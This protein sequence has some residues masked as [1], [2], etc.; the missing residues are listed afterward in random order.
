L[1]VGLGRYGVAVRPHF[2]GDRNAQLIV[3][4]RITSDSGRVLVSAEFI[5]GTSEVARYSLRAEHQDLSSQVQRMG[6]RF[7]R[8]I[9]KP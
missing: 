4:G 9:A 7:A 5:E 1:Q 8:A 6:E 2:A 3:N